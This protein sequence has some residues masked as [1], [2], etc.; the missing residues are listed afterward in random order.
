LRVVTR[1]VRDRLL[2]NKDQEPTQGG[3]VMQGEAYVQATGQLF[4]DSSH[5]SPGDPGGGRGKKKMK[6]GTTWELHPLTDLRFAVK[7]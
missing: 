4:F 3:N 2:H 7:P 5:A 1:V 6:A